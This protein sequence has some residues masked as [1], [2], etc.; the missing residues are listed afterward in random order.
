MKIEF[1]EVRV[2]NFSNFVIAMP[3]HVN[4]AN[5]FFELWQF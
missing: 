4:S 1:Y 2:L 5:D 3:I